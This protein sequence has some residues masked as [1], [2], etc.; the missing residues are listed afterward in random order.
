[1]GWGDWPISKSKFATGRH[2]TAG[3]FLHVFSDVIGTLCDAGNDSGCEVVNM[4]WVLWGNLFKIID[5]PES[6]PNGLPFMVWEENVHNIIPI[7]LE[8]RGKAMRVPFLLGIS[9]TER[10]IFVS[11]DIIC[12]AKAL[13][14]ES[15]VFKKEIGILDPE[16]GIWH[17]VLTPYTQRSQSLYSASTRQRTLRGKHE[18]H[19]LRTEYTHFLL[20]KI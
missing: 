20:N 16:T 17:P 5:R 8:E 2:Q 1:M 18:I 19:S 11:V 9:T 12:S 15:Q 14:W 10:D 6:F 7:G 13:P 4:K 3:F